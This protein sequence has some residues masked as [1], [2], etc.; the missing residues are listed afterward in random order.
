MMDVNGIRHST[1]SFPS[2]ARQNKSGQAPQRSEETEPQ[3]P[4][5]ASQEEMLTTDE[6]KFFAGLFP[7]AA[8]DIQ[9]Y[10]VYSPAGKHTIAQSGTLVDRR[11]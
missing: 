8:G 5:Q 7:Q 3:T 10:Q 1:A 11:G 2:L 6:K 9:S 4:P